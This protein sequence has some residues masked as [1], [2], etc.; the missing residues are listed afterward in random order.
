MDADRTEADDSR[1]FAA[2]RLFTTSWDGD[3][4]DQTIDLDPASVTRSTASRS[5]LAAQD[6]PPREFGAADAVICG[7]SERYRVGE[8]LGSGAGG[9]VYSLHDRH[10]DRD[11]ALKIMHRKHADDASR[12]RRFV[13]EA[14][15]A[16]NLDHP[17]IL[18]IYDCAADAEGR[19]W[20]TMRKAEGASL[21]HLIEQAREGIV[22]EL[23]ASLSD[24]VDILVRIC[25]AVGFAHSRGII[26]QDIKPANILLGAF[27]EIMLTDWGTAV[28]RDQAADGRARLMG[29]PMYMSPEQAARQHA[30]ERS[31][32]YCI[33]ATAF[34]LLVL[35]PPLR[36]LPPERF[37]QVKR[38]GLI[39][40]PDA[41]ERAG[42]PDFLLRVVMR[43][44]AADP[45]ERYPDVPALRAELRAYQGHQDSLAPSQRAQERLHHLLADEQRQDYSHLQRCREL[46]LQALAIWPDNQEARNG[47]RRVLVALVRT[48]C[49]RGDVE[50]AVETL[51]ALDH[52]ATGLGE[53]VQQ[54]RQERRRQRHRQVQLR[55]LVLLLVAGLIAATAYGIWDQRRYRRSWHTV[56]SIDCTDREAA[57]AISLLPSHRGQRNLD[58][59]LKEDGLWLDDHYV[60]WLED[61]QLEG[62]GRLVVEASW[63][64]V[65]DGLELLFQV[66]KPTDPFF[67]SRAPPGYSAQ[68]GGWGGMIDYIAV[69]RSTTTPSNAD[70]VPSGIVPDQRHRLI[71]E[72]SGPWLRLAVDGRTV[73]RR[74]AP[75]P[76]DNVAATGI[77]LRAWSPNPIVIHRITVERLGLPNRGSPLLAADALVMHG[78][79]HAGIQTYLDLA[80][81]Q[82]GSD[83]ARDALL[84]AL[85]GSCLLPDPPEAPAA[86]FSRLDAYGLSPAERAQCL[87]MLA[88]QAWVSGAWQSALA[89]AGAALDADPDSR[90]VLRL[91]EKR[92]S[93][94]P[95]E[96]ARMLL[97][98]AG[99]SRKLS[100]LDISQLPVSSLEPLR[101]L[102]LR[103]LL[104]GGTLVDDLA[105]LHGMRLEQLDISNTAVADLSPLSGM[106][107]RRLSAY[108]CAVSDLQPLERSALEY[109]DMGH[110][111]VRDLRPLRGL[112]LTR[113]Y[114]SNTAIDDITPLAGLPLI[115]LGL[116]GQ[117]IADLTPLADSAIRRLRCQV[118]GGI[119][120]AVL[121]GLDL[122]TLH[123]EADEPID[124]M[125]LAE[126]ALNDLTLTG[127][128]MHSLAGMERMRI[129]RLLIR[130]HQIQDLSPLDGNEGLRE[131]S[132]TS[133][134]LAEVGDL[135]LPEVRSL[136]LGGNRI[137]HIGRLRMPRLRYLN[138][139]G[140]RLTRVPQL[141]NGLQHLS[142][143][144]NPLQELDTLHSD[145]PSRACDL[146]RTAAAPQAYF[147]L[148]Q[149]WAAGGAPEGMRRHA[150]ILGALKAGDHSLLQRLATPIG[151]RLILDTG[152]DLS[153]DA[154]L[155]QASL[156]HAHLAQ[157]A[158]AA[159]ADQLRQAIG[160]RHTIWL[161]LHGRTGSWYWSDGRPLTYHRFPSAAVPTLAGRHL[162]IWEDDE[163]VWIPVPCT[164]DQDTR[165]RLVL[166]FT[167]ASHPLLQAVGLQA[168]SP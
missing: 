113:L 135:H 101:G 117:P 112:P 22:P 63:K 158:T 58:L 26:H 53:L 81:D 2:E 139:S 54:A 67:G 168:H 146:S 104:C 163:D 154:A 57:E 40:E 41:A 19:P 166:E 165:H 142:L 6:P 13:T 100:T 140:N 62:S 28:P 89:R 115:W 76:I 21:L 75:L 130:D 43:C 34:H 153:W 108:R 114:A 5:R 68:F 32:I 61:V 18:P 29:T 124:L 31:D 45:A 143:Q 102:Q 144:D 88:L 95:P 149:A 145:W 38:S 109:L 160:T 33:G 1:A 91:L 36:R 92:R 27:G 126:E 48:A 155:Q 120:L 35:R 125:P 71:F 64:G 46:F 161:G 12:V 37:W 69:N 121:A 103:R 70:S 55:L 59:R 127:A 116:S 111:P 85:E 110:C 141:P 42:L 133:G 83:L 80:A 132:I 30:D 10:L 24:R 44:L 164:S 47:D 60:A 65:V 99:R 73:H 74:F 11:V 23:I 107:L 9:D 39:D 128:G 51:A 134:P 96:P 148:A 147:D 82:P 118:A 25:D 152:I 79:P 77:G 15:I 150:L 162:A 72:R 106:P 56:T 52:P 86:I 90:I 151:K 78:R 87:G 8:V 97:Q 131:V 157:A 119:D 136:H 3:A 159:E 93:D 17:G 14:R 84:R 16:A 66:P 4:V 138:L 7:T 122:L 167:A 156:A 105:P 49:R 137:R 98:L 129:K 123:L 94:V 20:F 50:Y